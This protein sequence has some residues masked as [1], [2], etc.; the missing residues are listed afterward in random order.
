[1][2]PGPPLSPDHDAIPSAFPT[3]R[4]GETVEDGYEDALA[5]LKRVL[6]RTSRVNVFIDDV[7]HNWYSSMSRDAVVRFITGLHCVIYNMM[8]DPHESMRFSRNLRVAASVPSEAVGAVQSWNEPI[9]R[10]H[11]LEL[12]WDREA[13]FKVI[14]KRV[15]RATGHRTATD[16]SW[17][18]ERLFPK[19]TH[20]DP[21][22]H[23]FDYLLQFTF[24]RPRDV[25]SI[26]Q[27][28]IN[29]AAAE[30]RIKL[31]KNRVEGSV[32][33]SALQTAVA[34]YCDQASGD[35]LRESA[36][37]FPGLEKVMAAFNSW[38][39]VLDAKTARELIAETLRALPQDLGGESVD[40]VLRKLYEV[41]VIGAT[42]ETGLAV[43]PEKDMSLEKVFW[44]DSRPY[45]IPKAKHILIHP[46]FH[47]RLG[48]EW[49]RDPTR[50]A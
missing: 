16:S 23:A 30:G 44:Y 9:L 38:P 31:E 1:L 22:L 3:P 35:V 43:L 45:P 7:D 28:C 48:L 36:I 50:T 29:A 18:W 33:D 10:E 47:S 6:D 4:E 12:E 5:A 13:L 25:I 37:V 46:M 34:K 26:C 19:T 21:R 27:L 8:W 41:G 20:A 24:R 39:W 42:V 40:N 49:E 2:A 11:M 17:L 15:A 14:T 32:G